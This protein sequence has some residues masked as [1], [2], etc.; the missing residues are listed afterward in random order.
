MSLQEEPR[1]KTGVFAE[2]PRAQTGLRGGKLG[3]ALCTNRAPPAERVMQALDFTPRIGHK[4]SHDEALHHDS[5]PAR[6]HGPACCRPASDLARLDSPGVRIGPGLPH[7]HLLA[8]QGPLKFHCRR[9]PRGAPQGRGLD[10]TRTN[11][12][13]LTD[14]DAARLERSL[15]EQLRQSPEPAQG[16]AELEALLD[17]AAVVPSATIDPNIVTMN[18][19]VVLEEQPAGRRMTVTLVYPRDSDPE[20]SQVSVLSPVGRALIGARVGDTIKIWS[21][22][23]RRAN[24]ASSK[25]S[26]SPRRTVASTCE[27]RCRARRPAAN[28][29]AASAPCAATARRARGRANPPATAARHATGRPPEPASSTPRSEPAA[30]VVRSARDRP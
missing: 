16:T 6:H 1:G 5:P 2:G 23:T 25:C 9:G 18:S 19:T 13:R 24:C 14:L 20:R 29:A 4:S 28:A 21:R 17:A 11:E 30:R 12:I 8:D 26:T 3:G 10:M 27:G 15:I 7:S 22:A